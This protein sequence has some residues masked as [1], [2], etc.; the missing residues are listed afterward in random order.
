MGKAL[1]HGFM[2]SNPYEFCIDILQHGRGQ[3]PK[4]NGCTR[5]EKRL[6]LDG[7]PRGEMQANNCTKSN[8]NGIIAHPD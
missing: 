5:V 1:K 2:F 4:T 8:W 7:K 6:L 3:E